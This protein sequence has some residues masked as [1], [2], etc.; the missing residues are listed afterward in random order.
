[1]CYVSCLVVGG[2]ALEVKGV[3]R[4]ALILTAM[5]LQCGICERL[6]AII[7]GNGTLPF[8]DRD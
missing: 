2:N 3:E 1:M 5:L 8:I 4:E 6:H 7:I